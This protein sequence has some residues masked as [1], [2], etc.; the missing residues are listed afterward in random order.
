MDI[1]ELYQHFKHHPLISTDTRNIIPGSIFFALKGANYN[2][3]G[4]ALDALSKGAALAVIDEAQ[5]VNSA[6]TI[7]VDD[8][9]ETL[10]QLATYHRQ[11]FKIP[12]IAITGSNG[13]TTTKELVRSV[14]SE[15][16]KVL[17]TK[18]NL[19]NHIG[20][21]LMLLQLTNATEVAIIEMGANHQYEIAALCNITQPT[22]GIIT[23][24]GKAH[25]EGFG[26]FEGVKKTK[27]ELYDYLAS[28][29]GKA[30]VNSGNPFLMEMASE[31]K[32]PI[33]YAMQSDCET[34]YCSGSVASSFP[35][36]KLS[37]GRNIRHDNLAESNLYGDYNAENI[38]AAIT[39]GTY[40]GLTA[41]KVNAGIGKYN[42]ENSRSQLIHK[43]SNEIYLDAYNAN[44]SS[45][46]NAITYFAQAPVNNKCIILGDMFELGT[47][48]L[49]EHQHIVDLLQQRPFQ[50]VLLV[51]SDFGK[52]NMP[53]SFKHFEN[54]KQA[55]EFLKRKQLE[56][57][58]ILI[59]GSRGMQ[60]EQLLDYL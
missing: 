10:Q 40:M 56:E 14:L 1:T 48:S 60:M 22:H 18:G 2:G 6:Q 47:E 21:P 29:N 32:E 25:L 41:T 57:A 39:I 44:P 34:C 9:L 16:Y 24:V 20:V 45:V 13:K 28:H 15:Q 54:A 50:Q 55:G 23:N 7:L 51:G 11:Q 30:F 35:N 3:N 43:G 17:A 37:W 52:T 12:V 26:S 59:K 8:V 4:F 33:F 58:H 31:I 27:K 5:F 49:A 53:S 42:S 19:N 46:A 36:L 38:L